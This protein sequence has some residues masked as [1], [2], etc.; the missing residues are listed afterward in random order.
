M[1]MQLSDEE[2]QAVLAAARPIAFGERDRFL[3]ELAAELGQYPHSEIG[4]GLVHRLARQVQRDFV[5]EAR[6][7]AEHGRGVPHT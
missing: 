3:R 1:P 2:M 7:E 6:G 4:V 5:I